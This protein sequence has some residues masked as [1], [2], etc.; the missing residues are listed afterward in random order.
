MARDYPC[1]TLEEKISSTD[2]SIIGVY[3]I[4][5]FFFEYEDFFKDKVSR[6]DAVT[7]EEGK[8]FFEYVEELAYSQNKKVYK[9]DP[10]TKVSGRMDHT[11]FAC[12]LAMLFLGFF[13]SPAV[14]CS[15]AY[16]TLGT[17]V[18]SVFRYAPFAYPSLK[19][20]YKEKKFEKISLPNLWDVLLYGETDYRN[21]I[22]ADGIEKICTKPEGLQKLAC[23][24]GEAHSKP[25]RSYLKNP[26]FRKLKRLLYKPTYELVS[27]TKVKE[28]DN[29]T[30]SRRF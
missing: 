8:G 13:G 15:G 18:G 9:A 4:E 23:F 10:L 27:E 29:G 25:L 3:H 12:G 5:E 14:A 2:V 1:S 30:L 26:T 17:L 20:A 22:M 24:H 19:K 7:L 11:Q 21:I 16:L 6:S 28:Y